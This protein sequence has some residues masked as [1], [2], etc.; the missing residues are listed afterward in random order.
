MSE[1]LVDT[2]IIIE[3]LRGDLHARRVLNGLS[4]RNDNLAVSVI[5]V[6]ELY[7]GVFY[8]RDSQD[9]LARL[10]HLLESFS[11]ITEVTRR[12]VER[13]GIVRGGLSRQIRNQVG[14]LDLLIAA[15]ALEHD[16]ILL[17]GNVRDFQHVPELQIANF[18][19]M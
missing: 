9:A 3:I 11:E 7:E 14:D 16:R 2:D 18:R 5:T 4:V 6:G 10:D 17:T 1:Y 15:T 19:E 13:F 12:L 8:G